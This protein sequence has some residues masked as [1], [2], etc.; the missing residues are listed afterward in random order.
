M[1]NIKDPWQKIKELTGKQGL[2]IILSG[3]GGAGK[4]TMVRILKK[5]YVNL[6]YTVTV[7]TRP[8]RDTEIDWEHY[9]FVDDKEFD[10][11]L[12]KNQF[13]E[14]VQFFHY[15]YAT[16]KK[17]VAQALE[18][19]KDVILKIETQGARTLRK[20]IPEAIFVFLTTETEDE[21]SR[22]L[23]Q[24]GDLSPKKQKERMDIAREEMNYLPDYDYLIINSNDE[25]FLA[26]EK[27]RYIVEA[28]RLKI[29]RKN[30]QF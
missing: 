2:L 1:K 21:L 27:L 25:A 30:I 14:W 13:L 15:R 10:E 28:E 11:M 24:R 5:T 8:K 17:Q 23:K 19:G 18:K 22:R 12:E 7:T 4:D 9:H 16:P 3:P 20:I 26:A 6:H 29:G